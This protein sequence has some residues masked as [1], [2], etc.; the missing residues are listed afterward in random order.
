MQT[1]LW[2]MRHDVQLAQDGRHTSCTSTFQHCLTAFSVEQVGVLQELRGV[3][4]EFVAT[5]RRAKYVRD[6]GT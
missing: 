3:S 5:Q 6:G 2:K 1:A 4:K